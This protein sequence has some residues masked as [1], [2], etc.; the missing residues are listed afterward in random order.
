MT[1]TPLFSSLPSGVYIRSNS[2][3]WVAEQCK[4]LLVLFKGPDLRGLKVPLA[5]KPQWSASM[6]GH[7]RSSF[8]SFWL[9]V[10]TSVVITAALANIC[11]MQALA[12]YEI[13]T[14]ESMWTI[15]LLRSTVLGLDRRS[16][17]DRRSEPN[18]IPNPNPSRSE[19]INFSFNS[20]LSFR[21]PIWTYNYPFK[22][23]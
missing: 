1:R 7:K 16:G 8:A 17:S 20:L 10:Y 15:C 3:Q 11:S 4:G 2:A 21:S 23:G 9:F 5:P 6:H 18:P 12:W 19:P 13:I 14:L 22:F